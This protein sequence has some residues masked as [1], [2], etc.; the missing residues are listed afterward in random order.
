MKAAGN[1]QQFFFIPLPISVADLL[2]V[3]LILP[4]PTPWYWAG[5]IKSS[6]EHE[7]FANRE[8][9]HY[10]SFFSTISARR[11]N[12]IRKRANLYFYFPVTLFS[13]FLPFFS[14]AKTDLWTNFSAFLKIKVMSNI[15]NFTQG[16]SL[17]LQRKITMQNY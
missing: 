2:D 13:P 4:P 1:K 16:K 6:R 3:T 17:E 12:N 14:I 8:K 7:K 5:N 15:L 10:H 9:W 11:S